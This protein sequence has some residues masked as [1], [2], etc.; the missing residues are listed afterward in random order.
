MDVTAGPSLYR[1]HRPRTFADVVGQEHVVRTLRNAVEQG[2]VHHAYLF[3]GSRGTG[4]TSMAKMLAACM[5][6]EH[7]PTVE[8]CGVCESCVAIA[9]A[10]S[11]DVIEMDAASN[12]SVDDIRELRESVQFAPVSGRSKVYILDEAHMLSSQAWNAF[13]KTLE[14]PPPH[15]IFVL[16]TT[17]AQKVLPTVVD[18]C[19]RFDFARPTVEQI[20]TVIT[21]V[22][23]AESI[24]I[25]PDAVAL[26]ARHATGS[27]RDALG[28]LEQLVTYTGTDIA[29]DDVLAVLGV[30]DVDL[31]FEAF[32]AVASGDA[33]AAWL[34]AA[35]L[36]DTG[37]DIA[38]FLKD[39]EA[40]ARDLLVVQTLGE[41]PHELR[42]TPDRDERLA[43]QA[44]RI[45]GSSLVRLLDLLA[46]ALRTVKDGADARTRLEA[47]LV[48]AAA[49]E[50]D[51]AAR[52]LM[53]RVERL[54]AALSGAA[55]PPQ[56]QPLRAVAPPRAVPE[57]PVPEPDPEGAEAQPP[58]PAP[59]PPSPR[60]TTQAPEQAPGE[61]AGSAPEDAPGE[62]AGSTP[63]DAPGEAAGTAPEDA[64]GE[65]A[66]SAPE[67]APGD[68]AGSAAEHAP[69]EGAGSA[70]EHAPRPTPTATALAEPDLDAVRTLWPAVLDAV[71]A[72]N[73][74]L[75][76]C[77]AEAHPVEVRGS[78][79]IVAFAEHDTFNRKMADGREH[80]ATVDD[81][82]R[83]LA[84]SSLRVV[85]ELR[86]LEERSEVKPPSEDE[87]V[88]RFKTEFDAE[89]IV[90]DDPQ[91]DEPGGQN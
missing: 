73:G 71:R 70:A 91:P 41:V 82:L 52:A 49:P 62:A 90:P 31:L 19:H 35:R 50:V 75:A 65:A 84:G 83:D 11:L 44:G 16:A 69:G 63:E 85:F 58:A 80:R 21:R 14:E 60:S 61:A 88:A 76:A 29:T 67:H 89:E 17:E 51:P 72:D 5:N 68:G 66:G 46:E 81:A 64:P 18:R 30:A 43:E 53:A 34:A 86:E 12:N 57:K 4:K 25:A 47:A 3:V 36:A 26:L 79:V 78:E 23:A 38:Q 6:C 55:P 54:E 8:P 56:P 74:L 45:P 10:T 13:L 9:S 15:T 24:E 87:L 33:R 42:L 22:A 27:F 37:R 2:K 77:L 1:R 39:L 48:K 32:D 28:T 7:G 40:H 59:T 20:A